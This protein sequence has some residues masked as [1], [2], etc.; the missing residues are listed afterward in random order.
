MGDVLGIHKAKKKK[1]MPT[2][3]LQQKELQST[4]ATPEL[5]AALG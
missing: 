1:K 2:A 4:N 5:C 3:A